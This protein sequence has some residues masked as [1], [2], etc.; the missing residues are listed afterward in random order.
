MN[1]KQI[2]KSNYK[3][4]DF[5]TWQRSGSLTL[6][7]SFQRRGVWSKKAKSFLIDSIISGL[8]I[9]II[10]L[11]EQ[12]NLKTLEPIRE[13]VDGQQRL[14]TLISFVA[15][16]LLEDFKE[17]EDSFTIM[18]SHND[19]LGGKTFN[20]LSGSVKERILNYEFSVHI[21][22]PDTEDSE[23]LQIFARM[24]STGVKLNDQELRNAEFFGVFKSLAYRTA[25][26]HLEMWRNWKIFS[27]TEIARMNEVEETSDLILTML[28]GL[29][30]RSQKSLNNL[31][32]V[33]DEQFPYAN[34]TSYRFNF[35]MERIDDTIGKDLPELEFSKKDLIQYIICL[36][37]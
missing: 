13:V 5:I 10:F 12:T 30:G 25:Y 22:P 31:Y 20:Q 7:P 21:L 19:A 28:Q 32:K 34:T 24:N 29:K 37:L 27:E 23:V 15:P 33:Y 17:S 3:V 4:H 36:L 26:E 1:F 8:P 2:T 16:N 14:R 18:K 35:V 6:S 9:P 11:R